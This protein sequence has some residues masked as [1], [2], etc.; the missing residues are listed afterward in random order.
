VIK[1]KN[2]IGKGGFETD[3]KTLPQYLHVASAAQAAV[4]IG[5]NKVYIF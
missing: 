1:E 3:E 2:K 5:K 4:H